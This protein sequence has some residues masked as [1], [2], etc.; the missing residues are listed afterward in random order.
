MTGPRLGAHTFGFVWHR[1]PEAAF[2]AI[3]A[4]GIT[5]V[6]LMAMPPHFNPWRSDVP[7]TRRLRA[8]LERNCQQALALDLASSDI[9]LAS[10]AVAVV[11]F[12]VSA[13]AHAIA[14]AA[15][16]GMPWVC[17]GSGRRHGLLPRVNAQLLAPF[18]RTFSRLHA[19]AERQGVRL[20]LENH[21]QGLLA[22]A[23]AMAAFLD[24]EGYPDVGVIYDVAN[25]FAIGE[26]PVAGLATLADRV[27][28]V[29]L[30]DAPKG[31][32]RHDPIGSGDIDF[33]AIA[34]AL[35]QSG[36]RRHIVL[37]ILSDEPAGDLADGVRR[38]TDA[39][40]SFGV[41]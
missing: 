29:H 33:A 40:F 3:A 26:D 38:L 25:A 23:A 11:E 1:T 41:G 28:I 4:L 39:G 16:L 10:P 21:P 32:W 31:Q 30:S 35:C 2:D 34:T 13:Y 14:R 12:A 27:H 37:E 9:N 7:R 18:R 19:E 24:G 6:Q 15:E 8:C 36:F 22:D 20:I 17:I 5:H